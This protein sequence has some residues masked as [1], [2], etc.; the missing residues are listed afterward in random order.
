MIHL[1]NPSQTLAYLEGVLAGRVTDLSFCYGQIDATTG[2]NVYP[3]SR[4]ASAGRLVCAGLDIHGAVM[5]KGL[6]LSSLLEAFSITLVEPPTCLC[7]A[8]GQPI[9]AV[10]YADGAI[11]LTSFARDR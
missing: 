5:V 1:S 3:P 2:V 11:N 8:V 4:S 6:A 7:I 9:V 10:G